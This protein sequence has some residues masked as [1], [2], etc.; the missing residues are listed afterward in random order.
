[1][2][3]ARAN[4]INVSTARS[5]GCSDSAVSAGS[6]T[7]LVHSLS[8][9]VRA[10][11]DASHVTLSSGLTS[12]NQ[13][14]VAPLLSRSQSGVNVRTRV[15]DPFSIRARTR[16]SVG[17]SS[18]MREPRDGVL[19]VVIVTPLPPSSRHMPQQAPASAIES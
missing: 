9:A 16:N 4:P 14:S 2:T 18:T 3:C 12:F 5:P 1:M 19:P 10:T 13:T 6:A 11:S 7:R 8:W 15:T 17:G